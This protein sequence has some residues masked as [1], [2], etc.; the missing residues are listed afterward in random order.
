ML[1]FLLE[2]EATKI[3]SQAWSKL[4]LSNQ[5]IYPIFSSVFNLWRR[6]QKW[7]VFVVNKILQ[8]IEQ[9]CF[10]LCKIYDQNWKWFIPH[11]I[12][13]KSFCDRVTLLFER[14]WNFTTK[15]HTINGSSLFNMHCCTVIFHCL[16]EREQKAVIQH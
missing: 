7:F 3:D 15:V 6:S 10:K 9:M 5:L 13:S 14:G 16:K 4:N 12:A 8:Q 11:K 2:C 1:R